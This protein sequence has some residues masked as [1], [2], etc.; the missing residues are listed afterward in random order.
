MEI[1]KKVKTF[2]FQQMTDFLL[3][4]SRKRL[5][6]PLTVS[7]LLQYIEFNENPINNR[8][9]RLHPFI[10]EALD[11]VYLHN[12]ELKE[13]LRGNLEHPKSYELGEL[14]DRYGSD[15]N[16]RH[17]YSPI[18]ASILGTFTDPRILEIG[19][20]STNGFPYGGLNPGGSIKAWREFSPNSLI[21]GV[22]IDPE[23]VDSIDE[24]GFIMD[25]TSDQSIHEVFTEIK[26]N[27][28]TFDLIVDDG[29]HDPHANIR[30]LLK[31]F[32]LLDTGGFYVIEDVHG[33]LIPFYSLLR[34]SL[35]GKMQIF[36][37]RN[38]REGV[39]DN[40]IIMFTR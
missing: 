39:D 31:L 6:S 17:S 33:S 30:T 8:P 36:D 25:Q 23:A 37:L 19:L 20:G 18:Y 27:I 35:P 2:S 40:V 15:K 24:I 12:L 14:F 32:P 16:L 13:I 3:S 7:G 5:N 9:N 21:V 1:S 29:F 26:R 34:H 4:F 11:L 10:R 28:G 38:E 22:D